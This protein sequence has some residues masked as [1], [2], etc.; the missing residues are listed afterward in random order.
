M[1]GTK[2]TLYVS[3]DRALTH[4]IESLPSL[5]NEALGDILDTIFMHTFNNFSVVTD[6]H[7][8][9]LKADPVDRDRVVDN[10]SGTFPG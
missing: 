10:D 1:M 4:I 7:L 8:Q 9:R 3:R 6:E 2:S 5:D